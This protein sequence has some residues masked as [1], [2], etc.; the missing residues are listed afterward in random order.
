MAVYDKNHEEE[1]NTLTRADE[2]ELRRVTVIGPEEE[3]QMENNAVHNSGSADEDERNG[4]DKLDDSDSTSKKKGSSNE[5]DGDNSGS[6]EKD[7]F[8]GKGKSSK[9]LGSNL[10]NKRNGIMLGVT[11][12]IVSLVV[13]LFI[14][15]PTILITTLRD[16]IM[17]KMS[18]LQTSQQVRYRRANMARVTDAFS[19]EGR[20]GSRIIAEMEAD[21][22]R[23]SF[24]DSADRNRITGITLPG[25]DQSIPNFRNS[26]AMGAHMSDYMD[27]K[28]P[29]RTARWKTKRMDAFYNRY[30]VERTFIAGLEGDPERAVNKAIAEEVL[31]DDTRFDDIIRSD[32]PEGETD[33]QAEERAARTTAGSQAGEELNNLGD[34]ADELKAEGTPIRELNADRLL[35]SSLDEIGIGA[36]EN[37]LELAERTAQG[38]VGTRIWGGVTGVLN[39]TDLADKICIIKNRLQTA[40]TAARNY[41]ALGL[42]KYAMVFIKA[43]D[44]VRAGSARSSFMSEVMGRTTK[45]D[46]NG[47]P[48]GASP[49]MAYALK[50]K[51]SRSKNDTFKSSYG[52]D[53]KKTGTWGGV[54]QATNVPGLNATS[55]GVIQNPVFQI[56]SGIAFLVVGF[57]SGGSSAAVATGAKETARV[58]M[59]AVIRRGVESAMTRAFFK[60]AAKSL[61]L[62]AAIEISFEGIMILMQMNVEKTMKLA[63]TGQEVGGNL[64]DILTAGGGTA[65]KQRS[66]QAGMVPATPTQYAAAEIDYIAWKKEEMSKQSLY[67]R[68]FDYSNTDSLAF[69]YGAPLVFS[70]PTDMEGLSQ[71]SQGLASSISQVLSFKP[72]INM[73]SSVLGNKT[74][75]QDADQISYDTY[76]TEGDNSGVELATDHAGNLLPIMRSDIKAIDPEININEL[77]ASGDIDATTLEPLSPAFTG[78]VDNCVS[79]IDIISKIEFENDT[80][81]PAKDC[82]AG[83]PQTVKFKAHLA[84]LDMVDGVE[85]E[86]IPEEILPAGVNGETPSGSGN[87]GQTIA[88][89]TGPVIPC[90]G[91]PRTIQRSGDRAIWDG[92]TPTGVIGVN[93]AG[94]NIDVYVRDACAGQ[95]SVRTVVIGA[96]IHGSE[97]G[98]QVVAQELLFNKD[99]PPDVRIIAIPEINKAGVTGQSPRPRFNANGVN[100][101]R[102][103]DYRWE[104]ATPSSLD[105]GNWRGSSP[106]SEPE[107]QAV[108]T[109][110][111]NLG[112]SNLAIS[113]HDNINWVAPSGP[114]SATSRPMSVRY[115]QLADHPTIPNN[116]GFGFFESWYAN[117]TGTPALLV[118]LS[119]DSSAAYLSRHA[120][121]VVGLLEEGLVR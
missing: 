92:I 53:G 21:G 97:N 65:N 28:H 84:F 51:F 11:G 102:N 87:T 6:N 33:A 106:A 72:F 104:D 36:G 35:I 82:L 98:G 108:Q 19:R 29:L 103:F 25:G 85:A 86:F 40:T 45:L 27:V 75:A 121:A 58:S 111:T 120:D 69:N 24:G 116:Q 61:A 110:L 118:E 73:F 44:D 47:N 13:A 43:G 89:F 12:G 115:G 112:R 26:D 8:T 62:T 1:G 70:I 60:Q 48:I 114:N 30:G 107:T 52:V 74:Y 94:Q 37:V 95:S 105:T 64:G 15:L 10:L 56:G 50:G 68:V 99:L 71:R 39:P 7:L 54:Q 67:A 57:F 88:N 96:S 2:D 31:D 23:F 42:M 14:A 83:N 49:G 119:T 4:L 113:Y 41:R 46:S 5:K 17:N 101:N 59:S 78:H 79:A 80:S 55:C 109:F 76:I 91:Q 20:M 117:A 3:K 93:S 18:G 63:F 81:D 9:S 16:I 66:L 90:E 38:S 100:L 77:I 22:Y 32:A 34:I